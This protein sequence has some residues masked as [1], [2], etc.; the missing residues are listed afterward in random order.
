LSLGFGT[1]QTPI[2]HIKDAEKE[3]E[4]YVLKRKLLESKSHHSAII[5]SIMATLYAKSQE[6][7][8]HAERIASLSKMIG[9]KLQLSQKDMDHLHLLSMLHDIGKIG[10]D[11]WIL[12]KPDKLSQEEWAMMKKHTE[13]GYNIAMSTP[14]LQTAAEYILSHHE[15]WDGNGYP[16]GL[17]GENIPLLSRILAVADAYDAMTSGRPYS[18][19]LSSED[20]IA[21]IERNAGTQFDPKMLKCLFKQ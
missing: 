3:A 11:D 6:T 18:K 5:N 12:N 9:E 20:A 21:E 1:K 13:I 16:R 4:E 17:S 2:D 19:A 7:E 8:A 15:R 10:V 14:D